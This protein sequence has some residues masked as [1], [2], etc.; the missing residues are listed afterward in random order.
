MRKFK[1][2]VFVL[3][4]A[5]SLAS[6]VNPDKVH[7]RSVEGVAMKGLSGLELTARVDNQT[8]YN[9]HVQQGRLTLKDRGNV[10]AEIVLAQNVVVRRRSEQSVVLPFTLSLPN[11]LALLTLPARIKQGGG[12]LTVSGEVKVRAG[13]F[14]RKTYTLDP[15]ALSDLLT[16]MGVSAD[17]VTKYLKM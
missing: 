15:T 5:A 11:P 16:Q 3:L 12:N 2:A 17:D 13:L 7:L 9:I 8:C 6:C 4:V 14:M 10:V 1:F